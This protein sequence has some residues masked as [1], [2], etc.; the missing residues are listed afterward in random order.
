MKFEISGKP[1]YSPTKPLPDGV[2]DG[3]PH[4]SP[5]RAEHDVPVCTYHT[6]S[7]LNSPQ[8]QAHNSR[9]Y[10]EDAWDSSR[11]NNRALDKISNSIS[12]TNSAPGSRGSPA[13]SRGDM[14]EALKS[15]K[16]TL[17]D[18]TWRVLPAVLK[19]YKIK[20]ED[21]RK[22]ALFIAY[23]NSGVKQACVCSLISEWSSRTLPWIR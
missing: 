5:S 1:A 13:N 16:I 8:N 7:P 22:Y 18:P 15:F 2:A 12:P 14:P 20:D 23:S 3:S 4:P 6:I 11:G 9:N 21:W 19:K 10:R 17:E